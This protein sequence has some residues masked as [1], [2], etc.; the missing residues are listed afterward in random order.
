M[1][2]CMCVRIKKSY[3][4]SYELKGDNLNKERFWN[5]QDF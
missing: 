5:E 3:K 2:K 4:A 1:L